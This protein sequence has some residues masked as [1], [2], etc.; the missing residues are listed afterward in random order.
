MD[1]KAANIPPQN[2]DA[3]ASLLGSLLIDNDAFVKIGDSL[4]AED[5]YDGRHKLIFEAMESLYNARKPVD[6]L[7]LSEQ[8]KSSGHIETVGGASYLT[9]LTNLLPTA[10]NLDNYAEIVAEKAIPRGLIKTSPDNV[11]IGFN[12]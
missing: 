1:N 9:E 11:N 3:E 12:E 6:I 4:R 8:L 10:A 2:L 7:T 5:F